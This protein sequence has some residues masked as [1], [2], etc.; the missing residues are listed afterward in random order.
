MMSD[1]RKGRHQILS[2][3]QILDAAFLAFASSGYDAM[4]VRHL[5][6]QLGLSHETVRQRFGSKLDL[7]YAA[8]DHAVAQFYAILIDERSRLPVAVGDLEELRLTTR[9]F[10]TASIKFPNLANLVNHE[11]ASASERLDYVFSSGFEPGFAPLVVLLD[12][13][14]QSGVI[15]PVTIRDFFFLV[16]A[17]M[18]PFTQVGLSQAFN[19]AAGPLDEVTHVDRFLEIVFRGI[20]VVAQD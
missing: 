5:N 1:A 14:I 7:Y 17:G 9:S 15:Y 2:D 13:L 6:A 20:T 19:N 16:D 12:R 10:I 18:S 4:S 8:I 3:G 11:A